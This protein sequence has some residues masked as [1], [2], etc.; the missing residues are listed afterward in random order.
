MRRG[1]SWFVAAAVVVALFGSSPAGA[2][3]VPTPTVAAPM[4]A[5]LTA[6][7]SGI[8]PVRAVV[9]LDTTATPDQVAALRAVGLDAVPYTV[10]PMVAVQG[11]PAAIH[12]AARLPFVRSL[13]GNYPLEEA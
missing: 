11:P 2:A 3:L 9:S 8:G 13:W 1:G 12:A 6:S 10:L 7:L 4:D 5:I